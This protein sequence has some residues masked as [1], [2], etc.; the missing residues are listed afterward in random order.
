MR[1]MNNEADMHMIINARIYAG[2]YINIINIV[3][4]IFRFC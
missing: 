1:V 3:I 2:V 4:Y